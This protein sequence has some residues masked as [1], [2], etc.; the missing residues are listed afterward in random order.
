MR[1]VTRGPRPLNPDGTPK[2]YATYGAARRDLIECM[3][4]Y[5]SYCNQ[6]LPASLAIEHVQPKA[7]VPALR[8]E[9]DNFL[10]GCTNCN[11]TKSDNPVDLRDFI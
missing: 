6:K 3:G 8:L 10:L 1:P 11:S 5:C 7:L 4:Q 2:T 9:W